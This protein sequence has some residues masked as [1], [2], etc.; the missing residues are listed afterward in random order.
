MGEVYEAEDLELG[1]RVALKTLR[2]EIA[3]SE[4][5]LAR[6]KQE[7]LLAR[8][9][10]HPNVCRIFD[11]GSH[12]SQDETVAFLTME[13]LPGESLASR[14]RRGR[15]D[16][17]HASPLIAQIAAALS[18][19][20]RAGVVHRDLKPGNIML[21]SSSDS[22]TPR[23]V[24]TDFGLA[25][26]H[27]PGEGEDMTRA[28]FTMGT[29]EYMAPEQVEGGDAGPAADIYALG[30]VIFEMVTGELPFKAETP[31]ATAVKRLKGPP[32]SPRLH[33]REL[34]SPWERAIL[35]CLERD[36]ARRF[37]HV[38]DVVRAL[39][40]EGAPRSPRR[41]WL[42]LGVGVPLLI[43][44]AL[45]AYRLVPHGR[46]RSPSS[47]ESATSLTKA[48]RSVA[49]LGFKN[50][51]GQPDTAWLSTA[52]S[53]MFTTELAAGEGL[54][55][56][57]GE[58][59]ARM[60]LDLALSDTDSF[61]PDTLARIRQHLGSDVVIL[62]SYL[63]VGNDQYAKLRLDL[64]AQDTVAGETLA[65]VAETGTEAD[66]FALVSQA[67]A[68]LRD[69]LGVGKVS[70]AEAEE[71]R[72]SIIDRPECARLYSE[73]L[74]KLRLFD[75]TSA[76]DLFEK[77]AETEPDYAPVHEALA[78]ALSVLGYEERA[79]D[80]AKKAFDLASALSREERL[81]IEGRYREAAKEWDKA[82]E[83][84]RTLFGFFP[85][86]LEYGLRLAE[87]QTTAG[88]GT[89][90]LA[91]LETL[92]R[93]P[94][95]DSDDPRIDLAEA[96]AARLLSDFKRQEA[97]GARAAGKGAAKQARLLVARAR[98]TE[99]MALMNLGDPK[100]ATALLE[101]AR[102]VFAEAG[103][104]A[105]VAQVV[106]NM[107]LLLWRQGDLDGARARFE[108]TLPVVRSIGSRSGEARAL[109]NIAI[110]ALAQ[111]DSATGKK[112]LEAA[113]VIYRET[114]NLSVSATILNNLGTVFHRQGDLAAARKRYEEAM[115]LAHRTG[116]KD[117][118]VFA[119]G[120]IA[121]VLRL[122]GELE[123]AKRRYGEALAIARELPAK[124][125]MATELFGLGETLAA[126]GN[127]MAARQHY[128]EALAI[129]KEIGEKGNAAES[130]LAL[131]AITLEEDHAAEAEA[132]AR[133][134][135]EE[136]R[137]EKAP[138]LEA[139]ALTLVA[140]C[141]LV[142]GEQAEASETIDNAVALAEK[143]GRLD[144][145]LAAKITAARVRAARGAPAE[146]LKL[147]EDVLADAR[148]AGLV[149]L[150]LEARLALAETRV[151]SGMA[152]A[153]RTHLAALEADAR[154]TGF[155]LIAR[156]A[157]AARAQG[158][159]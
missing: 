37:P 135:A 20:H 50:L 127:L 142:R 60:K 75:A 102:G 65:S 88:K 144:A 11:L 91:T 107:G 47:Q 39:S 93:L 98:L 85:D 81:S 68:H 70:A 90:A 73:G 137:R 116:R 72:A 118:I 57:P 120:N 95:P 77:A 12:V 83:I 58:N 35:R 76:R 101:T 19:A 126:Q 8:K 43:L 21:V 129:Q 41:R 30:I 64:R 7:I 100:K 128:E 61:A 151:S 5:V 45:L 36:Q 34:P 69:R 49:V 52:L 105:G 130:R 28:G 145:R 32:P 1:Q 18:A 27:L 108:E 23:V 33:V 74:A 25:R 119:T 99:G 106:S 84:Y 15:M 136:F 149:G 22:D 54:R 141:L 104:Q 42:P 140:R 56:V 134:A 103:D 14:L 123:G 55:T 53:E 109:N 133:A 26:S 2:A 154:A 156:K 111:G 139:S 6:F 147:L 113:L 87:T 78:E 62:G 112:F 153:G 114:G 138:D 86:N 152:A 125:L 92:R 132:A 29:A 94:R 31:L 10:T 146:A 13:L 63:V 80:E 150:Q 148:K 110:V 38:E 159:S 155:G 46:L 40:G 158:R 124:G 67:G 4:S 82:V 122:Q 59:V 97:A 79:R 117:T 17:S 51:S 9:V 121:W 115:A 71:V 3:R 16:V 24:V 48:R 143:S 131:A 157:A 96:E 89:D 66:L 44:S